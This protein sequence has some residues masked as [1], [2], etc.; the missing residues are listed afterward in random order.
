MRGCRVGMEGGGLGLLV[1]SL[2]L[3]GP[4][5]APSPPPQKWGLFTH[6]VLLPTVPKT[7][8][9]TCLSSSWKMAEQSGLCPIPPSAAR[10]KPPRRTRH[11]TP[12]FMKWGHNSNPPVISQGFL[13]KQPIGRRGRESCFKNWLT[14]SLGLANPTSLGQVTGWRLRKGLQPESEAEFLPSQGISVFSLK[15][16]ADCL[17]NVGGPHPIWFIQ[18]LLI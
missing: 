14:W 17:H 8:L 4:F 9:K 5:Q 7:V 6:W 1:I 3:V 11:E 12:P 10:E 13:E 15:P 2:L 16:S 18:S